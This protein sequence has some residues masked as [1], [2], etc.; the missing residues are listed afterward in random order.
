M[1]PKK[2]AR[3]TRGTFSRTGRAVGAP[4]SNAWL[5]RNRGKRTNTAH[6]S[7]YNAAVVSFESLADLGV[8]ICIVSLKLT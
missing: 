1:S 3:D 7:T 8:E 2:A 6:D 4:K 5:T